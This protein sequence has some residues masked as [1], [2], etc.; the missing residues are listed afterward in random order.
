MVTQSLTIAGRLDQIEKI[1]LL[2]AHAGEAAGFDRR[3]TYACQLAVSEACENIIKHGYGGEDA[4]KIAATARAT[5]GELTVELEDTA[6]P[7]NPAVRPSQS[8]WTE[9]NPPVGGLGLLII[10]R[11]MD[12]VEYHRRGDHNWLR[13]RKRRRPVS[14]DR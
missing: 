11:V 14:P 13:M 3:T 7:F 5:P 4:G 6:P 10:H 1:C 12:E 9:D 8:T 2:I